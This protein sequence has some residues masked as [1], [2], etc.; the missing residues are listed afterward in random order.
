MRNEC[1]VAMPACSATENSA[2]R[3][4]L[5]LGV[6]IGLGSEVGLGLGLAEPEPEPELEP[7]PNPNPNPNLRRKGQRQ[8]DDHALEEQRH[9]CE[10]RE[11]PLV[12]AV[13]ASYN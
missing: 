5:W 10:E 8:R 6:G 11:Q 3:S 2:R 7:D 4:R 12:C 1:T 13:A 9:A